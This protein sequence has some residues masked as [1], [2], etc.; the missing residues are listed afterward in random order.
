MSWRRRTVT[1]TFTLLRADIVPR[2][3]Q[4]NR[5]LREADIPLVVLPGSEIQVTD[6]AEY[7]REFEEGLYCHLGD[8]SSYTLLEFNWSFERYPPD[9]AGLVKWLVERGMTPI[10]AKSG[11]VRVLSHGY[12]ALG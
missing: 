5:D 3:E 10:L 7:R 8:G 2:V 12:G 1:N 9:A 11:A 4:F 6:S